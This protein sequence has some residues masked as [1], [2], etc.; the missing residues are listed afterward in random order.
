MRT[1]KQTIDLLRPQFPQ[2]AFVKNKGRKSGYTVHFGDIDVEQAQRLRGQIQY[3][4][5]TLRNELEPREK[6]Q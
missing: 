5:V 4:I 2:V 6:V 3:Q 1:L